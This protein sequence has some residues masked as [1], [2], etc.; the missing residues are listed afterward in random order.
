MWAGVDSVGVGLQPQQNKSPVYIGIFFIP[1]LIVGNFFVLNLFVGAVIDKYLY[2]KDKEEGAMDIMTPEQKEW[3]KTQMSMLSIQ[4]K[5]KIPEPE[6]VIR[7]VLY[8]LVNKPAFDWFIT[9]LIIINVLILAM[10]H[11]NMSEMFEDHFLVYSNYVFTAVFAFEAAA[12]IIAFGFC[13]YLGDMWNRFDAFL[14]VTSI[15]DIMFD[16]GGFATFFRV[17]R[18]ARIVRVARSASE[19]RRMFQTIIASI[20]ALGNVGAL[21]LL[22]FFIFA[23]LGVNF[24]HSACG[25]APYFTTGPGGA[26]ATRTLNYPNDDPCSDPSM[27]DFEGYVSYNYSANVLLAMEKGYLTLDSS[28]NSLNAAVGPHSVPAGISFIGAT[29]A[30][31]EGKSDRVDQS[32][33]I[34]YM[35]YDPLTDWVP[36]VVDP[37]KFNCVMQT[38]K[39]EGYVEPGLPLIVKNGGLPKGFNYGACRCENMDNNANFKSFGTAFMTLIRMSTGEYWN[40]IQHDL[41]DEGHDL[42]FVYFFTF[43]ILAT[44]I[45]LNLV[46]AIMILNYDDSQRDAERNVNQDHMDHFREVWEHFDERGHGWIPTP[47]LPQLLENLDIPLGFHSSKPMAKVAQKKALQELSMQLPDHNGMIHYTETL[48][49]LA[50]RNQDEA[51]VQPVDGNVEGNKLIEEMKNKKLQESPGYA[52]D[53]PK[54]LQQKIA[55]LSFQTVYRAYQERREKDDPNATDPLKRKLRPGAPVD[56]QPAEDGSM[57]SARPVQS[58]RQAEPSSGAQP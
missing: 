42:A 36:P 10:K 45:M 27:L 54:T 29:F 38:L 26:I 3:R 6:M 7:R 50:Y 4:I 12:K 23:I 35:V 56:T 22:L 18:V 25:V 46:V 44:F 55:V 53:D 32:A 15:V 43:L 5:P 40:G 52:K 9:I 19:L 49:A 37:T 17:F 2:L 20:P 11:R 48:F 14:V 41:M 39:C 24:F 57:N 16:F 31:P 1:F 58:Y 8:K 34:D 30:F 28:L 21:L 13:D 33:N 51:A 47:L